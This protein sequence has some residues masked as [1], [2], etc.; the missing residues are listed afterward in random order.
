MLER[1]PQP[2]RRGARRFEERRRRRLREVDEPTVVREVLRRELGMSIEAQS[3]NHQPV[4]VPHQ[5]IGQVERAGL[6]F[7]K[8]G[9][10]S[11]TGVELV[12]VR[13]WNALASFLRQHLVQL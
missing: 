5:E 13:A 11:C 6:V 4:E 9:E 2:L 8:S 10:G 7:A 1:E 12:A 3:L